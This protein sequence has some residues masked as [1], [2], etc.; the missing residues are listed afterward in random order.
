MCEYKEF[1]LPFGDF[2]IMYQGNL[3]SMYIDNIQNGMKV[4]EWTGIQVM[5]EAGLG[6]IPI[7]LISFSESDT[8]VIPPVILN[9]Q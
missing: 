7:I 8:E 5:A 6:N 2:S 3:L 1:I 9:F 4:G